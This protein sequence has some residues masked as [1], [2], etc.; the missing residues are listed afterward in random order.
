MV[1]L[2]HVCDLCTHI[3]QSDDESCSVLEMNCFGGPREIERERS[4]NAQIIVYVSCNANHFAKMSANLKSSSLHTL[5]NIYTDIFHRIYRLIALFSTIIRTCRGTRLYRWFSHMTRVVYCELWDIEI[6][7]V[8]HTSLAH[9]RTL[10]Q[11]MEWLIVL[12]RNKWYKLRRVVMKSKF[13]QESDTEIGGSLDLHKLMG[14]Q[15]RV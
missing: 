8:S 14:G 10:S 9:S 13:G 5:D 12:R 7:C 3:P 11:N 15:S 4:V 1:W 6:S 2:G